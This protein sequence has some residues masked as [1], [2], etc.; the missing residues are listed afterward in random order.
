MASYDVEESSVEGSRPVEVYKFV[1]G[2]EEFFYSSGEDEITINGN[3]YTPTQI[4]RGAIVQGKSDR[5]RI[6]S[7]NV[8]A[9]N[10]LAQRYVIVPPG[11]RAVMQIFRVQRGD[12]TLTPALIY[13]G[14]VKSV[15]F[16]E[17][18]QFA[19]IAVQTI[20]AA[21]SR[22]IPRF[23]YMGMCNHV[24]FDDACGVNP[25][26]F[27]HISTVTA[28]SGDVLTIAGLSASGLD[29]TGGYIEAASATERRL[30]LSQ[31]GD[32]VTLLLPFEV[33]PLLSTITAFAGCN[34]ELTGDCALVFANEIN[35]GGFAFVPNRN[36]FT[37]G[38]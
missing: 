33:N 3:D 11:R 1:L 15:K 22:E 24:L 14:V 7:V 5:N 19:E 2:T 26:S 28:V 31:S 27:S 37:A 29:C 35:F 4:R 16:P 10:E 25:A 23:T 8:P 12:G 13:N 18:G 36:P 20:E 17:N 21:S 30:V 9:T 38:L 34:H 32:D 6:L